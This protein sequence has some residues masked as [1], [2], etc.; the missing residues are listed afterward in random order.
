MDE[1]LSEVLGEIL[2]G[3]LL[4]R[5]DDVQIDEILIR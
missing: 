4:L 1:L 3:R 2:G 5:T